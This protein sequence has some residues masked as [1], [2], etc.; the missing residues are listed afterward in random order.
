M[1]GTLPCLLQEPPSTARQE[2]NAIQW[3]QD[4]EGETEPCAAESHMRAADSPH[5]GPEKWV[6]AA[7][8]K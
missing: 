6:A 1:L 4:G 5:S 3:E 2:S 8:R 7:I